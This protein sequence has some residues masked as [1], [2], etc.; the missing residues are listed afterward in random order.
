MHK[1]LIVFAVVVAVSALLTLQA[2]AQGRSA[3]QYPSD[4]AIDWFELQLELAQSTPGFTPPV[5][6]RAF[7]YSG[8]TLYEAVVPGM[9]GYQSLAGQ[10][11]GLNDLPQPIAGV[12]YDWR[13][14]AN[15]ALYEIVHYMYFN[16]SEENFAK[17]EAVYHEWHDILS[18][19]V[20]PA[21]MEAS[22][23][24]G[25]VI[26]NAILIWSLA[27]RGH[28]GQLTNFPDRYMAPTGEG[29]WIPTPRPN[30][31]PLPALQPYW[32]DNRTFVVDT[33]VECLLEPPPEYAEEA[34]TAFYAEAYEVYET[35]QSLT[36]EQNEIALF[37]A[38]D[39][40]TTATPP[41][42]SISIMNQVLRQE[43][44][45][46]D[47]AVEAYAKVGISQ[48]DAF[49]L[50]WYYKYHYNLIRPITYIQNLIDEDWN[51]PIITDPVVTP[52][53]PEYPSG[54]SVQSGAAAQVLTD[55]FG[56]DYAFTD[57]THEVR[58]LAPRSFES[59]YAFADEAAISRLYGGI[60]YRVAIERGIEQG[61]CI[62]SIVSNLRFR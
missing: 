24:Q 57:H 13:V 11:N 23:T 46:L 14:V 26:A 22:L 27:D 12:E 8:V 17:M 51:T 20:E 40:G 2:V 59:F 28:E 35:V 49:I 25:R 31:D 6:S 15:R 41:G 43:D 10:L 16:T 19:E 18:N 1:R 36:R 60:H 33:D 48:A 62:G 29:L 61:M 39:P 32:G 37:W 7:A 38:D 30:G 53:F 21:V 34:G 5:V 58:G 54:H 50:S 42:H 45:T 56:D 3:D 55:L 4:I 47:I 9:P 52:P 44:A